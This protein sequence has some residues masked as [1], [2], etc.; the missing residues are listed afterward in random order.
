MSITNK[1]YLGLLQFSFR[2][3]MKFIFGNDQRIFDI[4]CR[5]EVTPELL[6]FFLFARK[7]LLQLGLRFEQSLNFEF[8]NLLCVRNLGLNFVVAFVLLNERLTLLTTNQ[9]YVCKSYEFKKCLYT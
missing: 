5:T 4:L 8:Q 9:V 3:F 1:K 7:L 2:L 6:D